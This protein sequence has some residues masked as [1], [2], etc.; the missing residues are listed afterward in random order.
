[1]SRGSSFSRSP[2]TRR[3]RRPPRD[4]VNALL[5]L[6]YSVLSAWLI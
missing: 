2:F 1:M 5:S 6:G 4:A 3:N